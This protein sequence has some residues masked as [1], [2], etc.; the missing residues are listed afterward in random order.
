MLFSNKVDKLALLARAVAR[1]SEKTQ[2]WKIVGFE[3][4]FFAYLVCTF[5]H[6][7]L[8]VATFPEPPD[9]RIVCIDPPKSIKSADFEGF[10][11]GDQI[12][13]DI[14]RQEYK[15]DFR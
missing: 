11:L 5:R 4:P 6:K 9:N 8:D 12:A 10:Q 2:P 3:G 7:N 1:V 14:S 13:V 15:G